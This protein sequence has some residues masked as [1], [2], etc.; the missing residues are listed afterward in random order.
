MRPELLY[1]ND[2]IEAADAIQRFLANV[3]RANF[4]R[5]ELI[6]SAVLQKLIVIGEAAARIPSDF[7][8]KHENVEWSD[9][10]AF[11][12]IAVHAYF[13]VDWATVWVTATQDCPGVEAGDSE[14]SFR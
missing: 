10:T 13:S 1:L 2:I 3:D 8:E 9:I 14:G 11:R 12:N 6:A 4:L 7:R 5:S